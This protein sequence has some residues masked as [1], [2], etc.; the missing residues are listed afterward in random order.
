MRPAAGTRRA[1]CV[2]LL[3]AGLAGCSA[4]ST[5]PADSSGEIDLRAAPT[6]GLRISYQVRTTATVSGA[7]VRGLIDSEK[8]ASTFQ[9]YSLEVSEINAEWFDVRITGD[10][11]PGVVVASFASD[12]S[13]RRFG[14]ETEGVFASSDLA[15]FPILGEGFQL[16]RDLSGHWRIGEARPWMRTFSLPPMLKVEMKGTATLRRLTRRSGRRAAEFELGASGE[17]E[18][19]ASRLRMSLIGRCWIDLATGFTLETKTSAPGQFTQAG[20]PVNM[21][22]LEERE[23]RGL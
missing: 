12:W 4:L 2:I 3:G 8:A 21:E 7:G 17:G 16:S 1:L 13:A 20:G 23:S 19:A 14:V 6:P 18:Y 9:R 15:S 22:I 5:D 10:G 11:L